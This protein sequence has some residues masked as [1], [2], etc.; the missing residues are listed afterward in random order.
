MLL[1][2]MQT[3]SFNIIMPQSL[4][5]ENETFSGLGTLAQYFLINLL[6]EHSNW[7]VGR[8]ARNAIADLLVQLCSTT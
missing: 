6:Q 2:R 8:K 1:G 7:R 3:F 4:R 5:T